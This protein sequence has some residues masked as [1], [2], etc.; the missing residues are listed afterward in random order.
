MNKNIKRHIKTIL[1]VIALISSPILIYFLCYFMSIPLLIF[2][3]CIIA[4]GVLYKV[5]YEEF[6]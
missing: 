5:C 4:V 3:L 6:E 2:I 1:S